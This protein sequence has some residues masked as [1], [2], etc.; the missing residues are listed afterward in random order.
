M[1]IIWSNAAQDDLE[2]I[3]IHIAL[4][5]V[6]LATRLVGTLVQFTESQLSIFPKSGR[7]GRISN[8]Y[9]LVSPKLP[10]IIPYRITL[11]QIHVLRVYH[12]SRLW[13]EQF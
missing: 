8:T 3:R 11:G 5:D 7:S 9:E 10:Y 13:P 2:N 4:N 12:T 6:I 1:K